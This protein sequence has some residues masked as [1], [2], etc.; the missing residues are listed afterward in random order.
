MHN[1]ERIFRKAAVR[2][3]W[4]VSLLVIIFAGLM[5][6]LM[7]LNYRLP[8]DRAPEAGDLVYDQP[9]GIF[10]CRYSDNWH[11]DSDLAQTG[12][13]GVT[14]ADD[15]GDFIELKYYPADNHFGVTPLPGRHFASAQDYYRWYK[16]V[17]S[18]DSV[19]MYSPLVP[20]KWKKQYA[21]E[22][23]SSYRRSF[24]VTEGVVVPD[25]HGR[26][27]I[28]TPAKT[29][30]VLEDVVVIPLVHGLLV[31]KLSASPHIYRNYQ[32]DFRAIL[33]SLKINDLGVPAQAGV[34]IAPLFPALVRSPTRST[35]TKARPFKLS[36]GHW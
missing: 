25:G 3:F 36:E 27:Q 24:P 5:A 21:S 23:S 13:P 29:I 2:W 4:L 9:N 15:V 22:F 14:F 26:M 10:T 20:A 35:R 7:Y 16:Q 31:A 12:T 11:V 19:A 28:G 34:P 30:L 6:Y 8:E 1:P 17:T 33:S 32:G 18:L